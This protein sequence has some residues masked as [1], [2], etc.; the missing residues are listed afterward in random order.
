MEDFKNPLSFPS[1]TDMLVALLNVSIIIA[2][3]IVVLFLIYSGF[4]YVT[5]RGNAEKVQEAARALTYGVIGGVIIIGS[6][7][8]TGIIKSTVTAF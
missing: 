5:A 1:I 2:I 4:L 7:A 3:P 8:I 6:V